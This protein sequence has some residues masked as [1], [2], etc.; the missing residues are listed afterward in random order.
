MPTAYDEFLAVVPRE[1]GL[2]TRR[3]GLLLMSRWRGED[4]APP[5]ELV[6]DRERFA[7]YAD[8]MAS[9]RDA[10]WPRATTDETALRILLIEMDALVG[11]GDAGGA[12]VV[13]DA[14]GIHIERRPRPPAP[15][16]GGDIDGG[17]VDGAS[18]WMRDAQD[19]YP[20]A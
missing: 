8:G 5:V 16:N 1:D 13:V 20:P 14:E 7:A 4:V 15:A 9:T 11:V 6:L 17:D 2:L 12:R 19:R 18:W 3:A 10:L